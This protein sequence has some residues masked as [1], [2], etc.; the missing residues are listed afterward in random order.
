MGAGEVLKMVI[1]PG[2]VEPKRAGEVPQKTPT[3]I[4]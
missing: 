1:S 2:M 3:D 4:A